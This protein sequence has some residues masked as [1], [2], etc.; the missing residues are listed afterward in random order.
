LP[1]RANAH[2]QGRDA[3]QEEQWALPDSTRKDAFR[4]F[5]AETA[6]KPDDSNDRGATA[7]KNHAKSETH[8]DNGLR[9]VKNG[10]AD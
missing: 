10:F 8:H 6:E 5:T 7:N 4:V 3:R 9:L 2:D 1:Q